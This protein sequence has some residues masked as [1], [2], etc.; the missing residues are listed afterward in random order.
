MEDQNLTR[1][2]LLE[3]L[4]K[5]QAQVNIL[6]KALLE[7]SKLAKQSR[8]EEIIQGLTDLVTRWLP[9]TTATY[10]NETYC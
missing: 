5:S 8:Y 1:E 10:V 6:Q 3:A 4:A 2:E 9:D 7:D